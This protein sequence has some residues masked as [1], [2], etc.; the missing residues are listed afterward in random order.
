MD[1]Q[2]SGGTPAQQQT[3]AGELYIAT[4]HADHLAARYGLRDCALT[5][6]TE[7]T[8]YNARY[9]DIALTRV[10]SRATAA[11]EHLRSRDLQGSWARANP[12]L[13]S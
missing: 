9:Y 1:A 4:S 10:C 2:L 6:S 11:F 3:T 5:V 8:W 7:R 12:W 13:N